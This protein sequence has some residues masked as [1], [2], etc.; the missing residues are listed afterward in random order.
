MPTPASAP[1]AAEWWLV[2]RGR[3]AF[4]QVTLFLGALTLMYL[5]ARGVGD[6]EYRS[7]F[8]DPLIGDLRLTLVAGN[9][10]RAATADA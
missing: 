2:S 4:I 10:Y 3:L 1:R 6:R 7:V 5:S 9:R 8:L